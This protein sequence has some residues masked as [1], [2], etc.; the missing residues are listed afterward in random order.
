MQFL[1]KN[2]KYLRKN[3]SENQSTIGSLVKKGQ[4]TI[5]NWENGISEPNVEELLILSNYFD[6]SLD[7]LIKVDLAQTTW[8]T[9]LRDGKEKIGEKKAKAYE[10]AP[11]DESMVLENDN[12]SLSYVMEEIK[13]LRVEIARINARLM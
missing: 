11:E 10:H 2:I 1:G 3:L 5:G 12:F 4:T 6:I 7:V 9:T 13:S 8:L